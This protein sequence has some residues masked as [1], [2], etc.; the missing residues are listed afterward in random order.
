MMSR[1]LLISE[2]IAV[3]FIIIGL[4]FWYLSRSSNQQNPDAFHGRLSD[5]DRIC[6][7]SKTSKDF[8]KRFETPG[9]TFTEKDSEA[10]QKV[11]DCI[12]G[13]L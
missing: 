3:I 4:V 2:V 9:E 7:A 10:I 1:K 8:L 5:L 13:K 6:I 11:T 12:Y